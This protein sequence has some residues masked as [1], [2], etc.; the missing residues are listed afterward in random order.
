M[1]LPGFHQWPMHRPSSSQR[2]ARG[3]I[4]PPSRFSVP[5]LSQ[6]APDFVDFASPCRLH[7]L[8][9]VFASGTVCESAAIG[10]RRSKG[11]R[12][13]GGGGMGDGPQPNPAT[14]ASLPCYRLFSIWASVA[15]T[16]SLMKRMTLSNS[17][18]LIRCATGAPLLIGFER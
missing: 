6:T 4:T 11:R 3:G 7:C 2:W 13:A 18:R 16:R 14:P 5:A 1:R 10:T 12:I 15:F 9:L 8:R 17:S